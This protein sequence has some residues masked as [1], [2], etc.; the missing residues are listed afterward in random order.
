[1]SWL[2]TGAGGMLGRDVVDL[3]ATRGDDVTPAAREHLDITDA[4]AVDAAVRGHA[5]VVNAAA[6]TDVDGAESNTETADAV[7]GT[8]AGLIAAACARHGARLVHVSTD[9]VFDGLA[10][11]PYAEDAPTAP[12]SAYGRSKLAGEQAVL[13]A[14]P[15]SAVVVRTAWLYGEHGR[16]FVATMARLAAERDHLD[17]VDDQHGQPTWSRDV[18]ERIIGL[19]DADAPGGVYHATNAGITTWYGLAR[20]VFGHLG[21]DPDRVRPTTTDAF[22]RPA[23]RPAYSVL[24]HTG[25][26]R[27]GLAPMRPW[28]DALAAA[29]PR[30]LR[31]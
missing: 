7:N 28:E 5:V 20:A 6:Y 1:M 29:A 8:G 25:W 19:V 30:M 16:N 23:P 21:L 26:S 18:A 4:G 13:D 12:R 24:G 3:L 14:L 2:V 15:G 9:Y 17:V 11:V 10:T 27:A 31:R 22:P